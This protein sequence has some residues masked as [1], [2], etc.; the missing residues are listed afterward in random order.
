MS[1]KE[2]TP[3]I[4]NKAADFVNKVIYIIY[5]KLLIRKPSQRM[6]FNGIEEIL[7]HP[8]VKEI[9][10][11]FEEEDDEHDLKVGA[12]FFRQECMNGIIGSSNGTQM[13]SGNI[14]FINV[15]NLY[16]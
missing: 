13:E 11:G 1:I 16:Y 3:G 2:N 10:E 5:F 14:N 6:G 12:T 7:N 15:E 9:G 8:W 4:S